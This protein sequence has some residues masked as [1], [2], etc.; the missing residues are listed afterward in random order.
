[1][2]NNHDDIRA[3]FEIFGLRNGKWVRFAKGI[4]YDAFLVKRK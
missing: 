2:S 4:D 1:M 3:D